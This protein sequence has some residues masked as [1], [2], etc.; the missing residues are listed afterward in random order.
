MFLITSR[1]G[2]DNIFFLFG[3]VNIYAYPTSIPLDPLLAT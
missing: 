1:G 2:R 3:L